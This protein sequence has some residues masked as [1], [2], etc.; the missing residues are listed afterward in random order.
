[1]SGARFQAQR[2]RLRQ[3]SAPWIFVGAPAAP[4]LPVNRSCRM[5]LGSAGFDDE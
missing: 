2:P 1:V 3:C 5:P 4:G